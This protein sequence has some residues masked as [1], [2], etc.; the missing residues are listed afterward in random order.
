MPS[1]KYGY[2]DDFLKVISQLESSGGKNLNH[3]VVTAPNLQQGTSAIGRY[4][5]MP[6]TVKEMVNRR[7]L[8]GTMTPELQDLDSMPPEALKAHIESNPG[9]EDQLAKDLATHVLR[10]QLGDEDK[11]AYSWHQ[12][13][14]LPP[15]DITPQQL[16]DT[17]SVGG[18]YV[19][20][21]KRIKESLKKK[22]E[23]EDE[24]DL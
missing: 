16:N 12:G 20:K 22:P 11:A 9:V 10:R 5:L 7:R 18:D 14:N 3:P 13:H 1:S 19:N 2:P 6:N 23:V 4:G 15:Q 24:D 8:S 21:F 17:S